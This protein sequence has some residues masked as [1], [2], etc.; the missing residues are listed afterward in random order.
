MVNCVHFY[1]YPFSISTCSPRKLND[2]P[3]KSPPSDSTTRQAASNVP[4]FPLPVTEA[5]Q[6]TA[7][8]GEFN[9]E[10]Q[11]I[12]PSKLAELE[13]RAAEP[14]IPLEPNFDDDD[15][16][17]SV[18]CHTPDKNALTELTATLSPNQVQM[19]LS[20]LTNTLQ[21]A[22]IPHEM[23]QQ[24]QSQFQNDSANFNISTTVS[25]QASSAADLQVN[26][27]QD[28]VQSSAVVPSEQVQQ[29][30]NPDL[31]EAHANNVSSNQEGTTMSEMKQHD[32]TGMA[33]DEPTTQC[34][35]S[36]TETTKDAN[37]IAAT[38]HDMAE[39]P[40]EC[41]KNLARANSNEAE[42]VAVEKNVTNAESE[43]P[44][45]GNAPETGRATAAQNSVVQ[46]ENKNIIPSTSST[47]LPV[48]TPDK[49][50]ST[51]NSN[52]GHDSTEFRVPASVTPTHEKILQEISNTTDTGPN[53][54]DNLSEAGSSSST[55]SRLHT[56]HRAAINPTSTATG[57]NRPGRYTGNLKFL[58][59]GM[60][61]ML[62][63]TMN[64]LRQTEMAPSQSSY[65]TVDAALLAEVRKENASKM[66]F[67]N[68]WLDSNNPYLSTGYKSNGNFDQVSIAPTD[69]S[70][71]HSVSN[72]SDMTSA[73]AARQRPATL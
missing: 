1:F 27:V 57:L 54:G 29:N 65:D 19:V 26:K 66:K 48:I 38:F 31:V 4:Q 52:Q 12:S 8:C 9:A 47:V 11:P 37:E 73:S 68:A 50:T 14:I 56:Q 42:T 32:E 36:E 10:V 30:Q 67:V 61:N 3:A 72:F 43:T 18:A 58:N 24:V 2:R 71:Q 6:S 15:S 60:G 35:N 41:D 53:T 16:S 45:K 62:M 63:H 69:D 21:K 22:N 49:T 7:E 39:S 13:E 34:G 40:Q 46:N 33:K 28:T 5:T 70:D 23:V 59:G 17:P 25:D 55:M 20:L 51:G 44:Q 64:H